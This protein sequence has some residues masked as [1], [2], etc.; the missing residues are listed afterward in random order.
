MKLTKHSVKV[1]M[2]LIPNDIVFYRDEKKN[3]YRLMKVP[4]PPV[5]QREALVMAVCLSKYAPDI[6]EGDVIEDHPKVVH[7]KDAADNLW[8]FQKNAENYE[9][10]DI[11]D[12]IS[13]ST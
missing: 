12:K 5:D 7:V 10:W 4:Y 6:I 3:C 11:T 1:A 9:F 8:I 2:S 13:P